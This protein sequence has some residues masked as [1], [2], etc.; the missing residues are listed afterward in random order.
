MEPTDAYVSQQREEAI[1]ATMGGMQARAFTT[2][3][4]EKCENGTNE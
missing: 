1:A 3:H 4:D 2:A